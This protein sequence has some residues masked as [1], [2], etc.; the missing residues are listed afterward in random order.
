MTYKDYIIE[1]NENYHVAHPYSKFIFSNPNDYDECIG[2]G[3]TVENCME[4]IDERLDERS[5]I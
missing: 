5:D 1:E 2:F 4:Q 3:P